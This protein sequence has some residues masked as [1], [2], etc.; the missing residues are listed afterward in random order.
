MVA[1]ARARAIANCEV[2]TLGS[3]SR[4][5]VNCISWRMQRH[6]ARSG[7]NLAYIAGAI[8]GASLREAVGGLG[9]AGRRWLSVVKVRGTARPDAD[10]VNGAVEAGGNIEADRRV[11]REAVPLGLHGVRLH[12]S[13]QE[14]RCVEGD[15]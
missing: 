4:N 14:D 15:S 2:V 8:A 11:L 10:V 6:L 1:R 7:A 9:F 13:E 5:A 3:D 12:R